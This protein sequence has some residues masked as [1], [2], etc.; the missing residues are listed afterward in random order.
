MEREGN[1]ENRYDRGYL[2]MISTLFVR[3][4]CSYDRAEET[5]LFSLC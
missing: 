4:V 2:Y 1:N 3:D 5:C